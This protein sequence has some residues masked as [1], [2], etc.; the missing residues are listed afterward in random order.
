M[1]LPNSALP[2]IYILR[3]LTDNF[4]IV[5]GAVRDFL[6]GEDVKDIDFVTDAPYDKMIEAFTHAGY[7]V[8]ET[9]KQF[10][11]LMVSKKGTT[12]EIANYRKD[13]VYLDGRRPES[14]EIGTLEEDAKRRD[15]TINA[16]Y[17]DSYGTILD[18]TK[19][20][21]KDIRDRK[22]RF[23]GNAEDRI[24]EDT[25]RVF[26]FY[27]FLQTKSLYADARSLKAVRKLY[28]E[29]HINSTPERV[30]NEIERMIGYD[31]LN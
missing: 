7:T 3:S 16:L 20:G 11:V 19:K 23:I 26:R 6:L 17:M 31:R 30:R 8:K 1:I 28:K 15:F 12:Y 2:I 24:K 25:L 9:G 27:R 22:L 13:G 29:A 21:L 14:C 18:P 10:L 4:H 5:G